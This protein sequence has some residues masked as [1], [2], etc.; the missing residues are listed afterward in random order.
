VTPGGIFF[1]FSVFT[2]LLQRVMLSSTNGATFDYRA[3][4]LFSI[5]APAASQLLIS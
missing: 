4:A 2:T 5:P 1:V 3:L